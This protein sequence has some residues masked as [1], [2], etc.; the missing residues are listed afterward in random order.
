MNREETL[1]TEENTFNVTR[2]VSSRMRIWGKRHFE[3]ELKM[4]G[5]RKKVYQ[6][7][8]EWLKNVFQQK[9]KL[10]EKCVNAD[11]KYRNKLHHKISSPQTI[12]VGEKH[13]DKDWRNRT[14]HG[15]GKRIDT[16]RAHDTE[17]EWTYFREAS[18]SPYQGLGILARMSPWP[19][20][21]YGFEPVQRTGSLSVHTNVYFR[22]KYQVLQNDWIAFCAQACENFEIRPHGLRACTPS[23]VHVSLY[24]SSLTFQLRIFTSSTLQIYLSVNV[25][26]EVENWLKI[27]FKNHWQN[28]S[29]RKE[30]QYQRIPK[31][32]ITVLLSSVKCVAVTSLCTSWNLVGQ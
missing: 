22:I 14:R 5:R 8:K 32:H 18:S 29:H 25:V 13:K 6:W 27:S 21:E 9:K 12:N 2:R 11:K 20:L 15:H 28:D 30:A 31:T 3:A 26:L 1:H 19:C 16:T 24:P 4:N 23:D 10:F 17:Y 7:K